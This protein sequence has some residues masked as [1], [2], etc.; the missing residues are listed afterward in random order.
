L[1]YAGLKLGGFVLVIDNSKPNRYKACVH[2]SVEA[3]KVSGELQWW[4]IV[5]PLLTGGAFGALITAVVTGFRNRIQPVGYR[6]E[7]VP[8]FKQNVEVSSLNAK[9]IIH[10]GD[11]EYPFHNMFVFD[12]YVVNR[13]NKDID[14]FPL[15]FT[16]EKGDQAIYLEYESPDRHHTITPSGVSLS[17][18]KSEVDIKLKPFNRK[19]WYTFRVY[20]VPEGDFAPGMIELSSPYPIRFTTMP[21]MGEML[22][23]ATE[24]AVK[25]GPISISYK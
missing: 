21:T 13:G 11:K 25:V 4:H 6:T 9:I 18:P 8:V 1:L 20:V 19:D 24:V 3:I 7:M 2:L 23:A 10:E 17:T 14:E 22:A 12:I 16:L 15:G 5:V